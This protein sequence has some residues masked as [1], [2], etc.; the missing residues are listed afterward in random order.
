MDSYLCD[1]AQLAPNL[2]HVDFLHLG[3]LPPPAECALGEEESVAPTPCTFT[4]KSCGLWSADCCGPMPRES[5]RSFFAL[6]LL[7]NAE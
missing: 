4:G 1:F 2:R 5:F 6:S 7:A 3:Q